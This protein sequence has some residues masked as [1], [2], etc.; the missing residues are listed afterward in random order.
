MQKIT[1]HKTSINGYET[2][3]NDVVNKVAHQTGERVMTTPHT[4]QKIQDM[5]KSDSHV[6]C[7]NCFITHDKSPNPRRYQ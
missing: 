2:V 3:C 5:K 7:D 1:V 4:K 6:L